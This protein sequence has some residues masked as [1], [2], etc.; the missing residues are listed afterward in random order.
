MGPPT[1]AVGPRS[2]G[3]WFI[4]SYPREPSH[5]SVESTEGGVLAVSLQ[6]IHGTLCPTA[7][8]SCASVQPA[9]W[10]AASQARRSLVPTCAAALVSAVTAR[11]RRPA[12]VVV[13]AVR[14]S[15][16]ESARQLLGATSL[17]RRPAGLE[18]GTPV[19]GSLW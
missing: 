16:R 7:P 18:A 17:T 2:S 12:A 9:S 3:E 4:E 13:P 19:G 8:A 5:R 11:E 6:R 10:C 1:W 14:T 15:M